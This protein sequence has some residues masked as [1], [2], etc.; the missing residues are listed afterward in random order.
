MRQKNWARKKSLVALS[1][2]IGIATIALIGC[3]GGGGDDDSSPKGY[4]RVYNDL[5]CSDGTPF[6]L[7]VTIGGRE[8]WAD[9]AS[10]SA[11]ADFSP[12]S[13]TA[14]GVFAACGY[15]VGGDFSINVAD[16][17]TYEAVV[18]LSNGEVVIRHQQGCPGAC[19]GG[20]TS[21]IDAYTDSG[22][23]SDGKEILLETPIEG[24]DADQFMKIK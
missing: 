5:M 8:V 11:C 12:G 24:I 16:E 14:S 1:L 15:I 17:C 6:S 10:W 4:F 13:Y 7:K 18:T 21:S 20:Q 2:I 22:Y 23:S 19:P 9:S 3:G